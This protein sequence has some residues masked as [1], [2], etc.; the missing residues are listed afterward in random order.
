MSKRLLNNFRTR[1][2]HQH[3]AV[4][5]VLG[6]MGSRYAALRMFDEANSC[7]KEALAISESDPA[8]RTSMAPRLLSDLAAI[9]IRG[10]ELGHGSHVY[11]SGDG[12][13]GT[14]HRRWTN[15]CFWQHLVESASLFEAMGD[16][17][18]LAQVSLRAERVAEEVWESHPEGATDF[19]VILI[20]CHK[21]LGRQE[22]AGRLIQWLAGKIR[23][24]ARETGIDVL[25]RLI[26]EIRPRYGSYG[27]PAKLEEIL[28]QIKAERDCPTR[29]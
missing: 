18:G 19:V 4:A 5:L 23:E 1:L 8:L 17:D 12:D 20:G 26:E 24:L 29:P 28:A 9:A 11:R 10:R 27:V 22:E 6:A 21:E 13:S 16:V 15:S 2:G 7:L 25:D 3:R 14:T